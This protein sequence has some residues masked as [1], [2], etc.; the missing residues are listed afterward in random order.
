[1]NRKRRAKLKAASEGYS[2]G[3]NINRGRDYFV[4]ALIVL[5]IMVAASAIG[6]A[7]VTVPNAVAVV[8]GLSVLAGV[9]G[10]FTEKVGF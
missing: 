1:M 5:P 8:L 4:V 7:T 2:K 9:F 3:F 6:G 10:S